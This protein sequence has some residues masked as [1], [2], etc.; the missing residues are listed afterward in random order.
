LEQVVPTIG[1]GN[2]LRAVRRHIPLLG[3]IDGEGEMKSFWLLV[4]LMIA[5]G[6]LCGAIGMVGG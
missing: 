6:V 4:A 3:S 2:G 1:G 5:A